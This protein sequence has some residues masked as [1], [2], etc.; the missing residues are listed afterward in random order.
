MNK[1]YSACYANL[2][3]SESTLRKLKSKQVKRRT[4]IQPFYLWLMGSSLF[5]LL[6][7]FSAVSLSS[8][9]Q[10]V[11][12]EEFSQLSDQNKTSLNSH[13]AKPV[14]QQQIHRFV[15]RYFQA[16]ESADVATLLNY[17]ADQ[18]DYYDWGAVQ[19]SIVRQEKLDYFERWPEV[20][21]S[22]A[23]NIEIQ[24]TQNQS[25]DT[26]VTYILAFS[27]HNPLDQNDGPH[28]IKGQARHTWHLNNKSG[29]L[30]IT[31]EHQQVLMRQR[32]YD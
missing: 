3:E 8:S 1:A 23:G 25:G 2:H 17:Y 19:K 26:I 31:A 32:Y 11:W 10:T 12:A 4:A 7:L 22:L 13:Q 21:Q 14:S 29:H 18:V 15:Q 16:V 20:K 6:T 27:V 5:S 9:S 30:Q 24:S 28:T